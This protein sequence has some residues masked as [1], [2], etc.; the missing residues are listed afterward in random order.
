M[1]ITPS[2]SIL[3]IIGDPQ[4][5]GDS[6]R[7]TL[8][9]SFEYKIVNIDHTDNNYTPLSTDGLII[10]DSSTS[11]VIINLADVSTYTNN[12]VLKFYHSGSANDV[13]INC[14]GSDTF[15]GSNTVITLNNQRDFVIISS[16]VGQF[17][18]MIEQS[19][20]ITLS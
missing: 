10:C 8:T 13:I 9:G 4:S 17:E 20:G 3:N 6:V 15:D 16:I 2:N 19:S 5:N 12:R 14:G 18:W 7:D 1:K 11:D